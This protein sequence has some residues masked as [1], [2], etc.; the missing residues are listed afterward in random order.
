MDKNVNKSG[1]KHIKSWKKTLIKVGKEALS[2]K[3]ILIK[4]DRNI[5]KRRQKHFAGNK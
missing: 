4:V 3:E 5:K 1:Q 2:L